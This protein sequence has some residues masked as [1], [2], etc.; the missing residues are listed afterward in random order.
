MSKAANVHSFSQIITAVDHDMLKD[1]KSKQSQLKAP[2]HDASGGRLVMRA[3]S[4]YLPQMLNPCQSKRIIPIERGMSILDAFKDNDSWLGNQ[5]IAERTGIPKST[6][7][8]LTQ[9]LA[10]SSCLRHSPV[11]RKYRLAPGV[12]ALGYAAI[13][14]SDVVTIARPF[15]QQ[16]ANDN[17]VFVALCSRDSLGMV[18]LESCHSETT[19]TTLGLRVGAHV[20]LIFSSV[21][22]ALLAELPKD[23]RSY[24]VDHV[25]RPYDKTYRVMLRERVVDDAVRQIEDRRYC[26]HIGVWNP[27]VSVIA[28][29][30]FISNKPPL[31]IGCAGPIKQFPKAKLDD[32][33]GPKLIALI[34]EL[35]TLQ[36]NN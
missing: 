4:E 17:G 1:S 2:Q 21:G 15:L 19:L 28:A 14:D 10:A 32:Q 6:V 16:F 7:T 5:E 34:S 31:A 33:V 30:L 8:R 13:A 25:L 24:L 9:T 36:Y 12:L 18:A 26:T 3:P 20:P 22:L 23:E 27:N 29:P 11:L 35:K